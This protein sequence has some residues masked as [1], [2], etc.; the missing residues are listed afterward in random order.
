MTLNTVTPEIT[1]FVGVKGLS[2]LD[3]WV[4]RSCCLLRVQAA[5]NAVKRASDNLVKAA[6]KAA[7]FEDQENETVVVK[8]K[9]VG[10]IAQ[11]SHSGGTQVGTGALRWGRG[12]PA[13][14]PSAHLVELSWPSS[15]RLSQPR[16]RCFG[17]SES[18][19]RRGRS[20]PRSGSSSTSFCLQSFEMSTREAACI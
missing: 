3:P 10:G 2:A 18:W 17:R 16:K 1:F 6:Q 5:G 11:V 7:A 14:A 13:S 8:E 12:H 19:K 4:L 20:W 15:L 9:M